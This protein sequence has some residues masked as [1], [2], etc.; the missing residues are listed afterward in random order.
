VTPAPTGFNNTTNGL[1]SQSQFLI[2]KGI[3][4]EVENLAAGLGP[5]FNAQSCRSCHENPVTGAISQVREL[6][7]GHFDSSS[8]TFTG[9]T[10]TI[11]DGIAV[12]AD[13]SP[14]IVN[15]SLIN[16]RAICPAVDHDPADTGTDGAGNPN[17][18]NF[19]NTSVQE[20]L[21]NATN[22]DTTTL[23]TSLNTLG[24][25]FVEAILD[26]TL[27]QIQESQCGNSASVAPSP[28]VTGGFVSSSTSLPN[29][30]NGICGE[31]IEV[32]VLEDNNN[33]AIGRFG[34]KD[35]HASLLSFA[36]DA[37]LNE[38]G[39]TN[40]LQPTEVTLYCNPSFV[41]EPNDNAPVPQDIDH[42]AE[43]MRSTQAPPRDANLAGMTAVKRGQNLFEAAGCAI[44]HA[45]SIKTGPAGTQTAVFN[46]NTGFAG[47]IPAA[48]GNKTIQPFGEFLLHDVGTGDGI[49][50]N[51]PVDTLNKVRTAPLWGVRMRPQLMHDGLSL[52]LMDAILRHSGE[53][54]NS[55]TNFQSLSSEEKQ[56][57]ILFLKSL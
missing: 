11:N 4:S 36:G 35:Q 50:Q 16:L 51:G 1:T 53:A 56:Q 25:G 22:A 3:F 49:V 18:F 10:V 29:P 45:E 17:S 34:W 19:P 26:S 52:T 13:G 38:M 14:Q 39:I 43:F 57:L 30:A 15:R 21:D 32:P 9:A 2:D 42:F 23:R 54:A 44:C 8:S 37:Y 41:T 28:L 55:I 6:R 31:A 47:G 46:A 20:R 40:R 12:T 27:L 48:L 5:V 33:T 7:A 24:D